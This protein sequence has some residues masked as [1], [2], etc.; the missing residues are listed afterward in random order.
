MVYM[1]LTTNIK[2]ISKK[3]I[4]DSKSINDIF[5]YGNIKQKNGTGGAQNEL[6]TELKEGKTI[7]EADINNGVLVCKVDYSKGIKYP[8]RKYSYIPYINLDIFLSKNYYLNEILFKYPKKVYFDIDIKRENVETEEEFNKSKDINIYKNQILE[9]FPNAKF[10][11]SGSIENEKISFHIILNNYIIRNETEENILKNIVSNLLKNPFDY[12]VYKTN[13]QMKLINQKKTPDRQPQEIIEDENKYN[14]IITYINRPIENYKTFDI[15]D[16]LLYSFEEEKEIKRRNKK[17]T[18]KADDIRFIKRDSLKLDLLRYQKLIKEDEENIIKRIENN[19]IGLSEYQIEI[20]KYKIILEALPINKNYG[21]DYTFYIMKIWQGLELNKNDFLKWYNNKHKDQI[22]YNKKSY[23]WDRLINNSIKISPYQLKTLLGALY[24]NLLDGIDRIRFKK[25]FDLSDKRNKIR[26]TEYLEQSDFKTD[27]QALVLKLPMGSGKTAQ[28]IEYIKRFMKL[29][30]KPLDDIRIL[31]VSHNKNL[32]YNT[33]HRFLK[34]GLD[35][36]R[37]YDEGVSKFK[38]KTNA[39]FIKEVDKLIICSNSVNH[40]KNLNFDLVIIDEIESILHNSVDLEFFRNG[41]KDLRDNEQIITDHF[42]KLFKIMKYT[43]KLIIIDAFINKKS[44]NLLEKLDIDYIIIEKDINKNNIRREAKEIINYNLMLNMILEDLRNGKKTIIFYPS[45]DKNRTKTQT[46]NNPFISV[47]NLE[48]IIIEELKKKDIEIKSI[49]HYSN[50]K[51]N[52]KL[53]N[54]NKNWE[55]VDLVISNNAITCGINYDNI[56]SPFHNMY[57][58]IGGHNN[59]YQLCQFSFRPRQ[60][61]G[62][63]YFN[64]LDNLNNSNSKPNIY[65]QNE[66]FMIINKFSNIET[67][68]DN[69]KALLEYFEMA[70]YEILLNEDEKESENRLFEIDYNKFKN[71]FYIDFDKIDIDD[72]SISELIKDKRRLR[73]D[74]SEMDQLRLNKLLLLNA[75]PNF[76]HTDIKVIWELGLERLVELIKK[77]KFNNNVDNRLKLLF[78]LLTD[79]NNLSH[80]DKTFKINYKKDLLPYLDLTKKAYSHLTA[81]HL[82]IKEFINNAFNYEIIKTIKDKSKHNKYIIE[83]ILFKIF[84]NVENPEEEKPKEEEPITD[85]FIDDELNEINIIDKIE[86]KNIININLFE[87][88]APPL[89]DNIKNNFEPYKPDFLDW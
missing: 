54:V 75:L 15:F 52:E 36:F 37:L 40:I 56:S 29:T 70:G 23:E 67:K 82:I 46:K 11:I 28:T 19:I 8:R 86:K 39:E 85:L 33:Y 60:L 48:R 66:A 27:T 59:A 16:K 31:F 89:K 45:R 71:W 41:S 25:L 51:K 4:K 24:K 5:F 73:Y 3:Y 44:I 32:L 80:I 7:N 57:I 88:V 6:I 63:I 65:S 77:I 55:S 12:N 2:N 30:N 17:E 74:F 87:G 49:T 47:D 42:D 22:N 38:F 78:K 20:N 9:F 21:Y 35:D 61:L 81:D 1:D 50:N 84:N 13:G 62:K 79:I 18:N 68:L 26:K 53:K 83:P 69:R 14:H 76:T 58:F 10:S 43:D 64:F 34:E 72:Y